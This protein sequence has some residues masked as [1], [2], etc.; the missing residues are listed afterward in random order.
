[1][2]TTRWRWVT[3]ISLALPRFRGGK[4]VAPQLAR[5]AAED[6][7]ASVFPDQ[8]ACGE[9]LVGE[10]EIPDHP[11]VRQTIDDCLTEAMDLAGLERLL[12]PHRA[13][14]DSRGR[15]RSHRTLSARARSVVGAALCLSRRCAARRAPHAGRDE[16]ALAGAR[17]WRPISAGSIP[18]RLRGCAAKHGRSPPTPMSCT[19]RWSGSATSPAEEREAGEWGDWLR[20]LAQQKR[21]AAL[22]TPAGTLWITAERLPEFRALWPTA[23]LL[24]E[25]A[26]PSAYAARNWSP[27]E[28][29]VE[30]LRGRL[31]G[32]GPVTE[33]AL[34]APLGRTPGDIAA[35]LAALQTEGFA[36]RGRFT[37]RAKHGRMVRAPPARAHPHLYGQAFARGNRARRG[38]RFSALPVRLAARRARCAHARARCPRY[39]RRAARRFRSCGRKLGDGDPARASWRLRTRLARRSLPGG[40]IDLGAAAAFQRAVQWRRRESGAGAHDADHASRTAPCRAYGHR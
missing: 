39:D 1:M 37:P 31:E 20:D 6:L 16:P 19:M 40:T 26:A 35:A 9:N 34:A 27:E 11:L 28:A 17:K 10:R 3:G 33:A 24:P 14:R 23:T 13:R 2:F 15:L 12:T 29:L 18:K 30:I 5:M 38:A 21:A 36:M 22:H 4:K 32:Q 25:I 8:V 7:L